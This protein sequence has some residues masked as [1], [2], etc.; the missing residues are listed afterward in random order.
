MSTTTV[1]IRRPRF[2]DYFGIDPTTTR[3]CS[4]DGCKK[5]APH[6]NGYYLVETRRV[7]VWV[8]REHYVGSPNNLLPT[9]QSILEAIEAD[10]Q[11]YA[12]MEKR[13]KVNVDPERGVSV[14]VMAPTGHG[15]R[16][17]FDRVSS[18][19]WNGY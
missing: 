14:K 15:A 11:H 10:R 17:N 12:N 1:R 5:P 4:E 6:V 16:V 19:R 8:C 13:Y 7:R 18:W 3:E 9:P 2:Y